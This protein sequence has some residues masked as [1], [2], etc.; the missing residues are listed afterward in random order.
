MADEDKF[1]IKS[2]LLPRASDELAD[3]MDKYADA[4]ASG[5]YS[6][7]NIMELPPDLLDPNALQIIG[8]QIT[9]EIAKNPPDN[10]KLMLLTEYSEMLASLQKEYYVITNRHARIGR[11]S[12]SV[13]SLKDAGSE[14]GFV[15]KRIKQAG[16]AY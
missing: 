14:T 2:D 6:S 10:N 4:I 12:R 3:F 11:I 15:R 9:E 7:V 1:E 8:N 13:A 5:D 16:G